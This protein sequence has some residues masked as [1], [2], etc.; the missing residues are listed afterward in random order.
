MAHSP[1]RAVMTKPVRSAVGSIGL[2]LTLVATAIAPM[3]AHH[4]PSAIFDMGKP[5]AV[6]GTLTRIDW[7]NPHIVIAVEAKGEGG[8]MDHWTFENIPVVV[9]QR[10]ARPGRLRQSRRSD[11][12][13][14]RR[15][16][17]GRYALRLHAEDQ[18]AGRHL[19]GT[20]Q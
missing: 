1:R 8:K 7:I 5:I 16:G 4:S 9:S 14:G 11:R 15:A 6:T 12:H 13:R 2:F 3:S 10:R 19:A 20:G 17:Q 18:A